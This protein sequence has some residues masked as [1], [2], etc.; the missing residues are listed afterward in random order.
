[1]TARR[2][3]SQAETAKLWLRQNGRCGCGCGERLI[4]G[5]IDVEHTL[6]RWAG[7]TDALDNLTLYR[8]KPCHVRKSAEETT[9]RAKALRQ[10]AFHQTGRSRARR[11]RPMVSR[12]FDKTWRRRMDGTVERVA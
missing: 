1:M 3:L 5:Q 11:G 8:R 2:K 6:P 10:K 9:R 4:A 7:G 12:G